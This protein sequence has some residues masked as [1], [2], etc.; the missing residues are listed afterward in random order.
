MAAPIFTGHIRDIKERKQAELQRA[1]QFAVT[2]VLS[3][4]R[5]LA[6][7]TPQILRAVCESLRW[8]VGAIWH[9]D[10]D[11]LRCVNVWHG[12]SDLLAEFEQTTRQATFD[13]RR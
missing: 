12:G 11:T 4:A 9:V 5:T 10:G 6:E 7:A 8:D 13:L 1:A 3:E 2:R